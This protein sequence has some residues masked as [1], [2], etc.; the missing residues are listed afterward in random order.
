MIRKISCRTRAV[1]DEIA[2]LSAKSS[3]PVAWAID[4]TLPYNN[5]SRLHRVMARMVER[6]SDATQ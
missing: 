3:A 1:M 4:P 6:G 5:T 2:R